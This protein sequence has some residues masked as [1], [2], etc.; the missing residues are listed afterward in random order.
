MRVR[1]SRILTFAA[2]CLA[3][4]CAS[5]ISA[6]DAVVHSAT[7][8]ATDA[9]ERLE[10]RIEGGKVDFS[11]VGTEQGLEV[12]VAADAA[13]AAGSGNVSITP[14]GDGS[15]IVAA[16]T[17]AVLLSIGTEGDAIVATFRSRPSAA[18]LGASYRLGIG[19]SVSIAVYQDPGLN[20]IYPIGQDG[21]IN[22]PLAGPVEAVGST[23][24]E[25]EA[26]ISARLRDFIDAPHVSVTINEYQSQFVYVTGAVTDKIALRPGRT[27][28]DILSE[29]GI[30]MTEGRRV[31][32]RRSGPEGG[33]WDITTADVEGGSGPIPLTGDVIHVQEEVVY[34][35][36]EVQRPGQLPYQA[37]MTLQEAIS[38]AQGLTD[39]ASR[40]DIV[41]QRKTDD[42]RVDEVVNLRKIETRKT[43]DPLLRP[44]DLILIRRRVL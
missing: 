6:S 44:G 22:V 33:V 10:I 1:K 21:S 19:D 4:L 34:I 28:K 17:G 2:A 38:M 25:L 41:I 12:W 39:W 16:A 37:G 24:Q 7:R 31:T 9:G 23:E 18:T 43:R 30:S 13:G 29:A 8:S 3:A 36:G 15:K 42:D 20:G 5:P 11:A 32:L 27:M 14:S 35:R 26:R 40:K